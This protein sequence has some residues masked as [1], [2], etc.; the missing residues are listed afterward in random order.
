MTQTVFPLVVRSVC[1][2]FLKGREVT[3]PCSCP[4][5]RLNYNLSLNIM[6]I[7]FR[8]I[9][10]TPR[11]RLLC[12]CLAFLRVVIILIMY[13]TISH[14]L[15]HMTSSA[16]DQLYTI[17]INRDF[18]TRLLKHGE[19]IARFNV[20]FCRIMNISRRMNSFIQNIY[21]Y[22]IFIFNTNHSMLHYISFDMALFVN[23]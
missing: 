3:L 6:G 7:I 21:I 10:N 1:H 9:Y 12:I 22:I 15:G 16:N 19:Y 11:F 17:K 8:T 18:L 23:R 2:Y 13:F 5:S 4:L 20:K 14:M